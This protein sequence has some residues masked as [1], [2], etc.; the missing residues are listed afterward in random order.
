MMRPEHIWNDCALRRVHISN[1][2][3]CVIGFVVYLLQIKVSYFRTNLD[4]VTGIQRVRNVDSVHIHHV[5]KHFRHKLYTLT[6]S[7]A[8]AC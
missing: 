5:L 6:C 3:L 8:W 1:L 7:S 4:T 2:V